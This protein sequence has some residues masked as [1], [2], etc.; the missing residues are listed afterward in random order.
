MGHQEQETGKSTPPFVEI[1]VLFAE[2]INFSFQNTSL[3][4]FKVQIQCS[5]TALH[6]ILSLVFLAFDFLMERKPPSSSLASEHLKVK[7]HSQSTPVTS[8]DNPS[9]VAFACIFMPVLK[10]FGQYLYSQYIKS[11]GHMR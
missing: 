11:S 2:S 6:V 10:L 4:Y 1:L 8:I 9:P 5:C 3:N 7:T